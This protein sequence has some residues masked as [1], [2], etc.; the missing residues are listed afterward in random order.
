MRLSS[1][2]LTDFRGYA[3]LELTFEPDVTVLVGVNG[4]GKTS[5]L[6]ALAMMLTSVHEAYR[7]DLASAERTIEKGDRRFGSDSARVTVT[8]TFDGSLLSWTMVSDIGGV[9][10]MPY[11]L[12]KLGKLT[13]GADD[14][15]AMP[16]AVYFPTNRSA[17]DIPS[18]IH[19]SEDETAFA[20]YDGALEDGASNFR[21]FFEWYRRE[22][23]LGNEARRRPPVDGV[24]H[25]GLE[26]VLEA[27]EKLFPGGKRLRIERRPQRMVLDRGE[28]VLDIAQLS[29]GEKCLVAMAGDLARRMVQVAPLDPAPLDREVI[30]LVDEIELHLHPGLQRQ[31]LTRLRT[32]FPKAQLVVSTHSPQVLSSV[33]QRSVRLLEGFSYKR[34]DAGTWKRDTNS[35]L[36]SAFG[37]SGRPPEIAK[38]LTALQRA[39]DED[40]F[41]TARKLVGELRAEVEGV[42]PE[43]EVQAQLIEPID[44]EEPTP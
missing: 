37:D 29:D 36:D 6:D 21:G 16:L 22:E 32:A 20:A 10:P 24:F 8:A 30:V 12:R 27:I 41:V 42:D 26:F 38:K 9:L 17:L 2:S 23:D 4:A 19:A 34:L 15:G 43:V 14:R 1:L 5:I 11:H 39:V 7:R 33:Q 31:I 44:N 13:P 25:A 40:D 28:E 18:R 35:I 3:S